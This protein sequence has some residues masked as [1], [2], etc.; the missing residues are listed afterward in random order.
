M[1]NNDPQI[2]LMYFFSYAYKLVINPK[3][4]NV[5]KLFGCAKFAY[6][7][8][9]GIKS[10]IKTLPTLNIN[11]WLNCIPIETMHAKINK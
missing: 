4:K 7:L 3:H 8:P 5:A 2:P 11:H 10:T 1:A 9:P 6:G